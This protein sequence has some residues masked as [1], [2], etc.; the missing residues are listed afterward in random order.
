MMMLVTMMIVIVMIMLVSVMI[1]IVV[2][3]VIVVIVVMMVMV[4]VV[5]M[6]MVVVIMVMM[7]V[8]VVIVGMVF[9]MMTVMGFS[10]HLAMDQ[11][12]HMRACDVIDG[13]DV[14]SVFHA[15]DLKLIQFPDHVFFVRKQLQQSGCKHVSCDSHAAVNK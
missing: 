6:V 13:F 15:R 12:G 3:V 2:V 5:M 1:V 8:V 4:I 14:R 9:F 10:L 11:H 7:I